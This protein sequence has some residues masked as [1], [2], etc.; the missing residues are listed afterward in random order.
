MNTM[1]WRL[2]LA[3]GIGLIALLGLFGPIDQM[4]QAQTAEATKRT[5]VAFAVARGLN[6]AI[7]AVQGTELALQPAGIGITLTP[8]EL[9]DPINDLV[10]RLSWILLASA[11]S[12]GVQQL[13]L[14]VGASPAMS[15]LLLLA[16]AGCA[17]ALWRSARTSGARP[18]VLLVRFA[19]LVLVLRFAMPVYV[20]GSE[21]FYQAFLAEQYASATQ[22]MEETRENIEQAELP[23]SSVGAA[24][25]GSMWSRLKGTVG[26]VRD[27]ADLD[28]RI[29]RYAAMVSDLADNAINLAVVFVVQNLLL[30]L[31]F[32][33]LLLGAARSILTGRFI[34]GQLDRIGGG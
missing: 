26:A 11:V 9:L 22:H 6:G 33:W 25:S 21:W 1:R 10:E 13:L 34:P 20:L 12:L 5:L 27:A 4:G 19:L 16:L 3:T 15:V 7:S 32:V 23:A 24:P 17:V 14:V 2:A 8:G 29:Q 28:Q 30:P 18:P 31:V